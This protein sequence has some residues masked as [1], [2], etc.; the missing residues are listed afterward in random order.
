MYSTGSETVKAGLPYH[1]SIVVIIIINV[2]YVAL[3]LLR[4]L[5][6]TSVLI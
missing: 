5:S 3:V 6:S 2:N 4:R 1:W